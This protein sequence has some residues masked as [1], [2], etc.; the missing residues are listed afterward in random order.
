MRF[1]R[2]GPAIWARHMFYIYSTIYNSCTAAGESDWRPTV[3]WGVYYKGS[4]YVRA[5]QVAGIELSL[6][7]IFMSFTIA[8]WDCGS[9]A[10]VS[11]AYD[12]KR[13]LK[14]FFVGWLI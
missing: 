9:T 6:F 4:Q 14:F 10:P 7:I 1:F 2:S 3:F 13:A 12:I 11:L 5:S 8:Q